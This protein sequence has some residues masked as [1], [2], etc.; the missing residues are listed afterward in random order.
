MAVHLT[1]RRQ[2]AMGTL[3]TV[4]LPSLLVGWFVHRRLTEHLRSIEVQHAERELTRSANLL[5]LR[6]ADLQR[7]VRDYAYWNA[8]YEFAGS[9]NPG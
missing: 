5:N 2:L 4:L 9:P 1:L 8:M 6:L 7:T 3:A